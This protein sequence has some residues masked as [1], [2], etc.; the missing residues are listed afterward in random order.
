MFLIHLVSAAYSSNIS[1]GNI[2]LFNEY[3]YNFWNYWV[4]VASA[5]NVEES[6]ASDKNNLGLFTS[7]YFFRHHREK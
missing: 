4:I 1:S 2:H 7:S 6:E 5:D 3:L